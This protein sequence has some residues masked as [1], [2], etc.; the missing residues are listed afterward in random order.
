MPRWL[1]PASCPGPRGL[2]QG[3]VRQVVPAVYQASE[4]VS[5]VLV[6]SVWL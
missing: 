2:L 5:Q 1:Q 3:L 4:E 6:L